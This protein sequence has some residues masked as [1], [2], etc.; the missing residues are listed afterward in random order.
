METSDFDATADVFV[1]NRVHE[2][3]HLAFGVNYNAQPN[4]INTKCDLQ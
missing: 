2:E 4:K 1:E 3:G